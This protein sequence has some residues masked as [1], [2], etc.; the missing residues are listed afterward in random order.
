MFG[1]CVMHQ[2]LQLDANRRRSIGRVFEPGCDRNRR[3]AHQVRRRGGQRISWEAGVDCT[4]GA[5]AHERAAAPLMGWGVAI[6]LY[7]LRRVR[8]LAGRTRVRNSG[9]FRVSVLGI[10]QAR[11]PRNARLGDQSLQ[12]QNQNQEGTHDLTV[13]E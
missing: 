9:C 13:S 10:V 4:R 3:T 2:K 8:V 6:T 5:M 1:A 7:V 12:Q 11:Y